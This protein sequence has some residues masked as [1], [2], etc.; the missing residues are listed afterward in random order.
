MCYPNSNMDKNRR[1]DDSMDTDQAEGS[2]PPSTAYGSPSYSPPELEECTDEREAIKRDYHEA[3]EDS[4]ENRV[5]GLKAKGKAKASSPD[6]DDD[7]DDEEQRTVR[8]KAKGKAKESSPDEDD[9]SDDE[10][11]RAVRRKAK[12]KA[13][14]S[15]PSESDDADD[16]QEKAARR[17]AKGKA[18][19]YPPTDENYNDD[20]GDENRPTKHPFATRLDP[21]ASHPMTTAA[22]EEDTS[23]TDTDD[24]YAGHG[25]SHETHFGD[26]DAAMNE[27]LSAPSS[28][29]SEDNN[30]NSE[31][32]S[33]TPSTSRN[34]LSERRG[35]GSLPP[36]VARESVEN[37]AA[38]MQGDGGW[39]RGRGR[40]RG[41]GWGLAWRETVTQEEVE[42]G[43]WRVYEDPHP[44]PTMQLV[45]EEKE[46][47]DEEMGWEVYDALAWERAAE[48]VQEQEAGRVTL[49]VPMPSSS[50]AR[51]GGEGSSRARPTTVSDTKVNYGILA[52][53]SS[54]GGGEFVR[55]VRSYKAILTGNFLSYEKDE[56][57]KVIYRD[58]DGRL[59]LAI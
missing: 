37:Y 23:M 39:G 57:L 1:R 34:P 12:G 20:Y 50:V 40:G 35:H 29:Y 9:D 8:R 22:A 28:P 43:G 13:K 31:N 21:L 18:R 7:S 49:E 14:A 32:D 4:D 26:A 48:R 38:M 47:E 6:E 19:A 33:F 45:G 25:Y 41:Q 59:H 46:E 24:Y 15:S 30:N 16:E 10:E 27:T 58:F 17:K 56:V 2:S 52:T 36:L 42:R 55:A 51:G 44:S 5:A 53:H 3:E 11:Q 54:G